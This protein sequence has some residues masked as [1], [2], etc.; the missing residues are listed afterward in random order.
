[1]QEK[2]DRLMTLHLSVETVMYAKFMTYS[3]NFSTENGK[4]TEKRL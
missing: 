2:Q 1:M 3:A 4:I